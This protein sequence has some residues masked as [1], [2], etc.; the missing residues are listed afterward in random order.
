MLVLALAGGAAGA[1]AQTPQ[2]SET[3][4]H[5]ASE[6]KQLTEQLGENRK[7]LDVQHPTQQQVDRA[8]AEA[9]PLSERA[10]ASVDRLG[11]RAAAA[12]ARLDELGTKAEKGE[13]EDVTKHRDE[14]QRDFQV[15]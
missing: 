6:I 13:T 11:P 15:N 10:K 14:V 4:E 7:L 12:K 3:Q 9:S 2:P 8:A 1:S 5:L